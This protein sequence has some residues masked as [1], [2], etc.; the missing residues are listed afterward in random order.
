MAA[1]FFG[2]TETSNLRRHPA[3]LSLKYS[4]SL[5]HQTLYRNHR[6]PALPSWSDI[7]AAKKFSQMQ[8]QAE[9]LYSSSVAGVGLVH[10]NGVKLLLQPALAV[11]LGRLRP[12]QQYTAILG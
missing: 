8:I 1:H 9:G 7:V 3:R 6:P 4:Q 12:I 2:S 11:L 10:L 5:A